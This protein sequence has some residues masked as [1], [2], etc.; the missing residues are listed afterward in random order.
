MTRIRPTGRALLGALVSGALATGAIGAAAPAEASCFSMFGIGNGNGC[1]STLTTY[2]IA[3]GDGARANAPTLFGGALAIGKNSYATT[4]TI[5][6]SAFNFA[7]AIGDDSNAVGYDSLFGVALQLGAGTAGTFGIGNIA[8]GV[9]EGLGNQAAVTG[10]GGIALQLGPG[11]TNTIGTLSLGVGV[12]PGGNPLTATN[13]FGAVALNL[14][15]G[16]TSQV[17]A[18]GFF[19]AAANILGND[20]VVTAEGAGGP[21]LPNWAFNALGIRNTVKAGPGPLT[22]AGSIFQRDATIRQPNTGFNI[23]GLAI[24]G[25][26]SVASV[27]RR[28][29]SPAAAKA[30]AVAPAATAATAQRPAAKA[31]SSRTV[32]KTTR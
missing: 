31:V 29:V 10:V 17:T 18:N 7:T 15:G 9:A 6:I 3:L 30:S 25:V 11:T 12:S 2:A 32:R 19:S 28:T 27:P 4:V 20:N 5:G 22:L 13:G 16:G 26:A 1:T 21:G 14:L 24:P 8:I 23:N